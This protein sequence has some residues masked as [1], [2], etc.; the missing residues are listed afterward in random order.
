MP[1]GRADLHRGPPLGRR[2]VPHP[3]E[4]AQGTQARHRRRRR[5]RLRPRP[6]EQRRG[7]RS[8]RRGHRQA[9]YE[10]GKQIA[11]RP[12]PGGQRVLRRRTKKYVF[13]VDGKQH[14][15]RRAD[16]RL[17]RRAGS[18]SIPSARSKTAGRGRLGRLEDARPT[19]WASKIQLVGDDLFVTNTKRLQRG[20]DAGRGQQHP[21]QGEPDRHADRDDRGDRAGPARGYTVVIEPPQRRDR[22][23]DHRRPGR[24]ARAP[25]RSRPARPRAPTAWPSTTS[26]CGSKRSSGAARPLRRQ[27]RHQG[28]RLTQWTPRILVSND[29][30]IAPRGCMALVDAIEAPRRGLGG[31]ARGRAERRRRTRISLHRPLRIRR[32]PA[33]AGSRSTARRPTAS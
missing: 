33:R 23:L 25:A 27:E 16:G 9:G 26:C 5:G 10:P 11:H 6:E 15:R 32:D 4:G 21:H 8:D 7:A 17:L 30:G 19:R 24:G 13:K 29:D 18:T 20:I 2:G 1:L 28:S 3:Q 31:R 14:R 22:G 12:R